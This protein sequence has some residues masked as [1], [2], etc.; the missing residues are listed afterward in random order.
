MKIVVAIL[1]V[2]VVAL[3]AAFVPLVEARN[4]EPLSH[5]VQSHV[6]KG[7]LSILWF[8]R[9]EPGVGHTPPP[10]KTTYH[11][12]G[13]VSV[14][15]TDTV[16]GT[17]RITITFYSDNE[18]YGEEFVLE[19]EPGQVGSVQHKTDIRYQG[20]WTWWY[21]VIPDTKTVTERVSVLSRLQG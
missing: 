4:A 9:I 11:P 15:N 6:E 3:V 10:V 12:I 19:L 20:D 5:E 14:K 8:Y 18:E 21:E 17:F 13:H 2:V 16:Q 1:V 7:S